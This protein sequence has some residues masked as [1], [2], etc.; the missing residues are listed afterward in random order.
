MGTLLK[1]LVVLGMVGM[2]MFS[3]VDKSY[4]VWDWAE[5]TVVK[6]A[7]TGERLWVQLQFASG[8]PVV[9]WLA[10]GATH[11]QLNPPNK[12][13]FYATLLAA[14]MSNRPVEVFT[15]LANG[16]GQNNAVFVEL[17]AK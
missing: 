12:K 11:N 13:E 4:A 5:A 1:S 14:L 17:R 2:F 10:D 6:T 3:T 9:L 15:D 8:S 16:I 7:L